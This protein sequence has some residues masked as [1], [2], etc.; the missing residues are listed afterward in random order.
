M[1]LLDA[2]AYLGESLWVWRFRSQ[3][4]SDGAACA[5]VVLSYHDSQQEW[6]HVPE[7]KLLT[8]PSSTYFLDWLLEIIFLRQ[9]LVASAVMLSFMLPLHR[10]CTIDWSTVWHILIVR[11]HAIHIIPN[12]HFITLFQQTLFKVQPRIIRISQIRFNIQNRF[13]SS[14]WTQE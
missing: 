6:G 11:R 7:I 13:F 8:I 14:P 10:C 12:A 5:C 3:F 2:V 9:T 4:C 1:L